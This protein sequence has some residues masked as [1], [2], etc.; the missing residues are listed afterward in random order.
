[1]TGPVYCLALSKLRGATCRTP[2][3]RPFQVKQKWTSRRVVR[4]CRFDYMGR[5]KFKGNVSEAV[6]SYFCRSLKM[7]GISKGWS[8]VSVVCPQGG[9]SSVEPVLR[10]ACYQLGL[11]SGRSSSGWPLISGVCPQSGL[12]SVGSVLRVVFIRVASHQLGLSS[13]WASSGWSSGRSL[14]RVVSISVVSYQVVF[15]RVLFIRVV[16]HQ[17]GL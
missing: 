4:C 5:S 7:R 9:L 13:G 10:V 8:P 14:I 15:V 2:V 3:L 12:S 1:M 16:S 6:G 17:G 11:S